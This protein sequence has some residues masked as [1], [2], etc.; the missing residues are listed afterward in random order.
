MDL[1]RHVLL[2]SFGIIVTSSE[3]ARYCERSGP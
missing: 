3:S 1:L 2:V